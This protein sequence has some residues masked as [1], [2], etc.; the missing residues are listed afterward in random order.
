[1]IFE[2][3]VNYGKAWRAKQLALKMVY[4]DWE[5]SYAVLPKQL[6]AMKARN[7]GMVYDVEGYP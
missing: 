2:Y 3:E 4:G 7:P 6:Q 5:E 1:M